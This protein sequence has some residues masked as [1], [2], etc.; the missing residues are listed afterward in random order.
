MNHIIRSSTGVLLAGLIAAGCSTSPSQSDTAAANTA[1]A[2][3]AHSIDR[4]A[5][6]P[7]VTQYASSELGRAHDSLRKAQQ[8][9][10]DHHDLATTTH[11]AYLAQQRA[12]TAQELADER[13][14]EESV[15]VAAA[16]RDHAMSVAAARRR[17]T[18]GAAVSTNEAQFAVAGF[19]TGK[20]ELPATMMPKIDELAVMLKNNPGRTVVIVGH[21][22]NVGS[23]GYNHTL[24]MERAQA[25]RVALYRRGV[26]LSR[27]TIRSSGEQNP[28]A[29]NGTSAGRRENRRA[30]VAI[31]EPEVQTAGAPRGTPGTTAV[32][33]SGTS[34]QTGQGGQDGK[35]GR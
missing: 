15:R 33:Q 27:V 31:A 8:T 14:A 3:A 11:L 10:N 30:D 4:A 6:D 1:I 13:A 16:Q 5:S 2:N 23:P 32:G 29:S 18:P 12:S 19:A 7:H 9:W 25:V 17:G 22:D 28:V 21:T 34:G 20:A 24:A 26:D 35:D